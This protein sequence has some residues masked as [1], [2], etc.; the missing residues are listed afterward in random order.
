MHTAP[1]FYPVKSRNR[2]LFRNGDTSVHTKTHHLECH[3]IR[4]NKQGCCMKEL[5]LIKREILFFS[6]FFRKRQIVP[7][8]GRKSLLFHRVF[9]SSIAFTINIVL[10]Q[11][12][13]ALS[14]REKGNLP[15]PH[16]EKILRHLFCRF[17][18]FQTDIH[19][20]FIFSRKRR[21]DRNNRYG[22][23]CLYLII[24]FS[25]CSEKDDAIHVPLPGNPYAFLHVRI[26]VEQEKIAL[27]LQSKL[28]CTDYGRNKRIFRNALFLYSLI[29][30]DKG[31]QSG[32]PGRKHPGPH[33]GN[34]LFFFQNFLDP[35]VDFRAD[36]LFSFMN[37][38]GYGRGTYIRE[39]R[40]I[41]YSCHKAPRLL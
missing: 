30:K 34:I 7:D 27:F 12:F 1:R 35:S 11:K 26:A 36:F 8:S 22:E 23:A 4:R 39:S 14:Q 6:P 15:V 18:V 41:F 21:I 37:D 16:G 40:N 31:N 25:L 32:A 17:I 3:D 10:F 29:R 9:I 33:V 13:S 5:F 20:V 24:S 28:H 2:K 38:I 19:I